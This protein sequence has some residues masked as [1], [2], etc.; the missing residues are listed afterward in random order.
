MQTVC[1]LNTHLRGKHLLMYLNFCVT[2]HLFISTLIKDIE[3]RAAI[4][5]FVKTSV[6]INYLITYTVFIIWCG[7]WGSVSWCVGLRSSHAEP[8]WHIV[9]TPN[10]LTPPLAWAWRK[11]YWVTMETQCSESPRQAAL[12]F[13]G[14]E[15]TGL[16]GVHRW[17][18]EEQS[19]F[20][21]PLCSFSLWSPLPWLRGKESYKNQKSIH[22]DAKKTESI[23]FQ[24]SITLY[25]NA[26]SVTI[27]WH[28][29]RS[30]AAVLL[31]N[32]SQ[33]LVYQVS[34]R[35]FQSLYL[36]LLICIQKWTQL[37]FWLGLDSVCLSVLF[38]K[39][40]L[41]LYFLPW[42]TWVLHIEDIIQGDWGRM[43]FELKQ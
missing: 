34:G 26:T 39:L 13:R 1:Q 14:L 2:I 15:L 16:E 31:F 42:I 18:P 30:F 11:K 38:A 19:L 9:S 8:Q 20:V 25:G 23:A 5:H 40:R 29:D 6:A 32:P 4:Y 22:H 37:K 41:H 43:D 27:H 10:S 33:Y 17:D 36:W 21:S 7:H 28:S 12:S 35:V 24:D 3:L